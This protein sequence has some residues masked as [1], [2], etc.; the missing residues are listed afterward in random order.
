[1]TKLRAIALLL[2]LLLCSLTGCATTSLPSSA[3]PDGYSIKS[4]AKV[5]AGTPFALNRT[6][7]VAAVAENNLRFIDP[8]GGPGRIIAPAPATELSFSPDGSRLAAV[9]AAKPQSVLQLFDLEGKLLAETIIRGRVT[10]VAWR[11]ENDLLASA[12]EI[13]K[14]TFG[15]ELI[16]TLYRWDTVTPPVAT[17]LSDVTVRP[18]VAKLPEATLLS[19][20]TMVLSPYGDEVAYSTLKDPPLFTP[21]LRIAVRHLE[22][23]EERKV[24]EI[25]IGS[26]GPWYAPDGASLLVGDA[27]ALSRRLTVPEGK[28]I[29]AWPT[30]GDRITG[31]PSGT[32][33]LLDDRLYRGGREILSFPH[34]SIGAFLPDG[35]GLAISYQG[36]LF[37]VTGLNDPQPAGLPHGLERILELRRLQIGRAHV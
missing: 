30:P 37:L 25:G 20:L 24:A 35:S 33:L 11:S 21:Y 14:F 36:T 28:E 26:G 29:D 3:L 15:S 7:A 6:G 10:S 17:P 23:G 5:D 9:F 2:S 34:D 32:Y 4:L 18:K 16:S 12:L 27:R 31:S 1:M 19:S 22:S 13:K 8:S